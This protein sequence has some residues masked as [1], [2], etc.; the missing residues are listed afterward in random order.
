MSLFHRTSSERNTS[1]DTFERKKAL[2][3][4]DFFPEVPTEGEKVGKL[5]FKQPAA[6]CTYSTSMHVSQMMMNVQRSNGRSI[7]I[8]GEKK[9]KTEKRFEFNVDV[10]DLS[11]REEHC[12]RQ[13]T[14]LPEISRF[15]M[16]ESVLSAVRAAM[17]SV[18]T[19]SA[20]D[21][22]YK[23]RPIVC[24]QPRDRRGGKK[25]K[26]K[27]HNPFFLGC[28]EKGSLCRLLCVL[29]FF[30]KVDLAQLRGRGRL[31]RPTSPMP[32]TT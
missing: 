31:C 15:T 4:E 28:G 30:Y 24:V 2:F 32:S 5:I 29:F 17:M 14:F 26:N 6:D 3:F 12:T 8:L 10:T 20:Y 21:K 13:F 23:V 22:V 7:D 11:R 27:Q 9:I 18:K 16:D 25:N 1:Q 19:P